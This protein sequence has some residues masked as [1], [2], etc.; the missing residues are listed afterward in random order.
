M[1]LRHGRIGFGNRRAALALFY[2][3]GFNMARRQIGD[4]DP[5]KDW[6]KPFVEAMFVWKKNTYRQ[7]LGLPRMLK[8]DIDALA[9]STPS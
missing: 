8:S 1:R 3:N 6:F 2:A 4:T 5:A 7:E 9:Y